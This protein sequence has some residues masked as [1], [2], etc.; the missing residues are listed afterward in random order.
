MQSVQVT[1]PSPLSVAK[2]AHDPP[3]DDIVTSDAVIV[4]PYVACKPLADDEP[5]EVIFVPDIVTA[6]LFVFQSEDY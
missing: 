2:V 3:V 5:V 1:V 6:P 4:P